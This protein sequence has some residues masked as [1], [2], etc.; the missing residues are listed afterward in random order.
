MRPGLA[1]GVNVDHLSWYMILAAASVAMDV[2]AVGAA[3]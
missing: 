2:H 1:P 3:S